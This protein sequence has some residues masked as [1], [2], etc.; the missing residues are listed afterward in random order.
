MPG[1]ACTFTHVSK[2]IL[3]ILKIMA[4]PEGN[5]SEVW[6]QGTLHIIA[7]KVEE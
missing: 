2:C 1:L 7:S 5:S 6:E 4:I 3:K